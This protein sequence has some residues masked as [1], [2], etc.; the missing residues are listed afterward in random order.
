M[1]IELKCYSLVTSRHLKANC[2]ESCTVFIHITSITV[3]NH[4]QMA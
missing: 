3:M 4:V 2:I 1:Y